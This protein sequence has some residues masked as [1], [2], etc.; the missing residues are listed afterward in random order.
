[1]NKDFID[2]VNSAENSNEEFFDINFGPKKIKIFFEEEACDWVWNYKYLHQQRTI[3]IKKELNCSLQ[4]KKLALITYYYRF[5]ITDISNLN[6]HILPETKS[7]LDI[8]AGIGLFDL[9]LNQLLNHKASFDLIEVE[10]LDEIEHVTNNTRQTKKLEGNIQIKPV[11]T[12][13]KLM[14][15]NEAE[16]INIILDKSINQYFHK[17]YDLILSFRSWGFLYDLNLYE[18]F[19]RKTLNHDGIVITDLSIYDDSIEKFSKLFKDVTLIQEA[20]NNKRFIG[21]NLKKSY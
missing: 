13:K 16:N 5:I 20:L 9:S 14:L 3:D 10:E 12:L 21:K 7:I 1:M 17:K 6:E 11:Q 8:G 15:A 18:E 4:L 2:S 19:V